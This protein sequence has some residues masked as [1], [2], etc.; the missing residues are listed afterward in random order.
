MTGSGEAMAVGQ[1]EFQVTADRN[2]GIVMQIDT[3]V[4]CPGEDLLCSLVARG[5][6]ALK[7][8]GRAEKA[9]H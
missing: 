5:A 6:V 7:L 3:D 2:E 9:S 4:S 1:G 8:R